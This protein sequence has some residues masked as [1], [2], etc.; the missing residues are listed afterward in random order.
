MLFRSALGNTITMDVN[1]VQ[2]PLNNISLSNGGPMAVLGRNLINGVASTTIGTA[3]NGG[4]LGDGLAAAIAGAFIN[5]G[6]AVGANAIGGW[7]PNFTDSK[8]VS[9]FAGEAAHAILGCVAGAA[10]AGVNGGSGSGGCAGGASGAVFGH[11]AGQ[12]FNPDPANN[13]GLASQTIAIGNLVGGIAGA[14]TAITAKALKLVFTVDDLVKGRTIECKDMLDMI[15]AEQ[16]I[17]EA[18]DGLWGILQASKNFEGEQ[19]VTYPKPE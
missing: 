4:D 8:T 14:L 1:G 16:Q 12:A 5:T 15:A 9:A 2:T 19:V 17:R 18:A 6:A 7:A 3:I 11:L 13:P 10:S